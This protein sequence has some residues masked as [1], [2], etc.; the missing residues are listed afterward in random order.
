MKFLNFFLLAWVI[1]ALLDPDSLQ[2][3]KFLNFFLLAWVIFA[4]VDPDPDSEYGSGSGSTDLIES[5][6]NPDPDPDPKP[7][8]IVAN[9]LAFRPHHVTNQWPTVKRK[10][11]V[12][13]VYIFFLIKSNKH[14]H[15]IP[16]RSKVGCN[17]NCWR[18]PKGKG[19]VQ[20]TSDEKLRIL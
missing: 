14:N 4:L 8:I 11:E 6:S 12:R 5:G 7:C 9:S 10:G 13:K 18:S 19:T 16:S 2:N 3:M 20:K 17:T 1:F 15:Q